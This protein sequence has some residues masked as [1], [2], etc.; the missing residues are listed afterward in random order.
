M[1]G[2]FRTLLAKFIVQ[3]FTRPRS[4]V[5]RAW[6]WLAGEANNLEKNRRCLK[7]V[8]H[9]DAENEEAT[10]APLLLDQRRPTS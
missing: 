7:T 8:L 9:L 2:R 3:D 5:I 10:L 1:L 6:L 4:L